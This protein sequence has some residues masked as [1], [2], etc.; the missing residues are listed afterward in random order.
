MGQRGLFGFNQALFS[1]LKY[2]RFLLFIWVLCRDIFIDD[3]AALFLNGRMIFT[4]A[5]IA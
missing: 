3:A 4:F 2:G 5:I 1:I